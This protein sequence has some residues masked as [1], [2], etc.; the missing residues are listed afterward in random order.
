MAIRR[1][2]F[3]LLARL[4]LR[5]PALTLFTSLTLA[6]V[7]GWLAMGLQLRSQILDLLPADSP[8]VREF[9][10]VL[11]RQGTLDRLVVIIEG[12]GE[13]D[14]ELREEMADAL[15]AALLDEGL[16]LE[17]DYRIGEEQIQLFRDLF[18]RFGLYYLEPSQRQAFLERLSDEGIRSQVAANRALLGT[19]ASVFLKEALV[20]DPLNLRELFN[21]WVERFRGQ[22][23]FEYLDGYFFTPDLE[24]LMLIV[25]PA[26][27]AQDLAFV[28]QLF[29]SLDRIERG[30]QEKFTTGLGDEATSIRF[31]HTGSFAKAHEYNH[32]LRRDIVRNLALA[33]VAIFVVF[34]WMLGG[35]RD[36]VAVGLT[37]AVGLAWVFGAARLL[38]GHFNLFT[39]GSAAILLGLGIDFSLHLVQRYRQER[40][41]GE[42]HAEALERSVIEVGHG[43]WA[44]GLTTSIGFYAALVTDF[45][46]L[47]ELGWIGG[48][49]MLLLLA[50]T[51]LVLPSFLTL[52]QHHRRYER[53]DRFEVFLK[54]LARTV[55]AAPGKVL[56]ALALLTLVLG[57]FLPQLEMAEGF[58]AFS[59]KHSLVGETQAE[60]TRK[61]GAALETT[62]VTTVTEDE[63]ALWEQSEALSRVLHPLIE[64]GTLA[65]YQSL[66]SVLPSRSRQ[67]QNRRWI[68]AVRREQPQS[69][70]LARIERTL[71]EAQ[72]AHGFRADIST[73]PALDLV[74]G[75]VEAP[76]F[77]S[78]EKLE[79]TGIFK[80]LDRFIEREANGRWRLTAYLFATG[81]PAEWT[82]HLF[83][84]RLQVGK[85]PGHWAVV[86]LKALGQEVRELMGKEAML[87]A[88]VALAGIIL[89]LYLN[90]RRMRTVVMCLLPL[91]LAVTWMLGGLAAFNIRFSVIDAVLVPV[92]MGLGIDS[93]IYLIHRLQERHSLEEG[94]S[95]TGRA[96][97]TATLTTMIGFGSLTFSSFPAVAN[98]GWFMVLGVGSILV[99]YLTALPALDILRRR[100]ADQGKR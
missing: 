93:G 36:L 78:I 85:L 26:G 41:R 12:R 83:R 79:E 59:P 21:P 3:A 70:D 27:T 53:K 86:S 80:L 77:L 87:A 35:V 92:M 56:A 49:G 64:N 43:A 75:L 61:V 60:I 100:K 52:T 65:S 38:V 20:S 99:A 51:Y 23:R 5:H 10:R 42:G 48:T 90:L 45:Q 47:R 17:V 88:G 18:V 55:E 30:I 76:E 96:M 31:L 4:A 28:Q 37:L 11:D 19:S 98:A 97:L 13:D 68:E 62:L 67:E 15:A 66:D 24:F 81:G 73:G 34:F 32:I 82:E 1:R 40:R 69:I 33:A 94:L 25:R 8:V 7:C 50:S 57:V 2:L 22:L 14:A 63:E 6:L 9:M 54:W 71:R 46:G 95:D 44:A 16:A 91:G 29:T 89:M 58:E 39:A 74:R 72:V 84:I